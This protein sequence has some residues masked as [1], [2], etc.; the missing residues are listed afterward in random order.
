MLAISRKQTGITDTRVLRRRTSVLRPLF[1]EHHILK[2]CDIL[3]E[4]V[5]VLPLFFRG[6]H[7]V[8]SHKTTP[9]HKQSTVIV[10][11]RLITAFEHCRKDGELTVASAAHVGPILRTVRQ[12]ALCLIAPPFST[13]YLQHR[14]RKKIL[15]DL[16]TLSSK[17]RHRPWIFLKIVICG[18]K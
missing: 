15:V 5:K 14:L 11:G 17:L 10:I 3:G 13:R 2:P 12:L 6:N 1:V 4:F 18:K 9:T 7:A 8:R 16:W